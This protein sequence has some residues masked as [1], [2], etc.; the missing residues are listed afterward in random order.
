MKVV[1]NSDYGGYFVPGDVV[2]DLFPEAAGLDPFTHEYQ[3]FGDAADDMPRHDAR[4]VAAVEAYIAKV[5]EDDTSLAVA[6]VSGD[7]YWIEDYDGKETVRTPE[8]IPWV[9]VK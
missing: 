9:K 6:D 5:G 4:L 3:L 7:R 1:Y 8:T 2:V